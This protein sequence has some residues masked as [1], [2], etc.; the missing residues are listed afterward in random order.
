M[1]AAGC[2]GKKAYRT[3]NEA[4]RVVKRIYRSIDKHDNTAGNM[5][6]YRCRDCQAFH[7]GSGHEEGR[8]KRGHRVRK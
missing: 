5:N 1:N 3:Y 2:M 6:A 7:L 8:K 4:K